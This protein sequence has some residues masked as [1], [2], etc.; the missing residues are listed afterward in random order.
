MHKQLL[1]D[2]SILSDAVLNTVLCWT[3]YF[4]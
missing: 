4:A 1:V 3:G 2:G